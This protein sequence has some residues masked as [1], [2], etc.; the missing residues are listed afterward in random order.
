[1]LAAFAAGPSPTSPHEPAPAVTGAAPHP[2]TKPPATPTCA[3]Q[4]Y[5]CPSGS[6]CLLLSAVPPPL[7]VIG[8]SY[9]AYRCT[10]PPLLN[11][12]S[13]PPSCPSGLQLTY[14]SGPGSFSVATPVCTPTAE[15]CPRFHRSWTRTTPVVS[16]PPPSLGYTCRYQ[17]TG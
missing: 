9:D 1:M 2:G 17:Y 8:P 3:N 5:V 10:F 14:T 11:L 15:A 6:S 7:A 12:P 13:T 4:G 16:L